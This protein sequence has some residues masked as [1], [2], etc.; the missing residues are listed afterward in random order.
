MSIVT[1]GFI[2]DTI[3]TK[4]YGSGAL[5]KEIVTMISA[6]CKMVT[7]TSEITKSVEMDSE[8]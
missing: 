8:L 1:K 4:G 6:I 7:M 2:D 5:W 3:I